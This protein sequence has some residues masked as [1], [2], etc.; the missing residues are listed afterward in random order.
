VKKQSEFEKHLRKVQSE[1]EEWALQQKIFEPG[2]S[3]TV[4]MSLSSPQPLVTITIAPVISQATVVS[5]FLDMTIREFFT[6]KRVQDAGAQMSTYFQRIHRL[7]G[8]KDFEHRNTEG[9]LILRTVGDIS[10]V[11]KRGLKDWHNCNG[12][13]TIRFVECIFK[14]NGIPFD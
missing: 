11:G 14:H 1:L 7:Q 2:E 5:K 4:Q 3:L 13:G 6:E 9:G 12:E 8:E 10:R